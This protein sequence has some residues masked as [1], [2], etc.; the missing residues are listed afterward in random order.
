M[1]QSKRWQLVKYALSAFS[2]CL[3]LAALACEYCGT[4]QAYVSSGGGTF[5]CP[6]APAC[7]PDY[8]YS[9][10]CG[11]YG[12]VQL[13]CYNCTPGALPAQVLVN[14]TGCTTGD[15]CPSN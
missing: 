13:T 14:A 8:T 4:Y 5:V 12:T 1:I 3:P 11:A 9:E 7:Q 6:G 10:S 2:L 15:G